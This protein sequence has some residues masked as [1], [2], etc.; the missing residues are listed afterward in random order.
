MGTL[1][2]PPL[3]AHAFPAAGSGGR[4]PNQAVA[5]QEC[6]LPSPLPHLQDPSTARNQFAAVFIADPPPHAYVPALNSTA[7]LLPCVAVTLPDGAAPASR[8]GQHQAWPRRGSAHSARACADKGAPPH[9]PHAHG[10]IHSGGLRV[11]DAGRLRELPAPFFA[12]AC[13]ARC[14][15][16]R[17]PFSCWGGCA[18]GGSLGGKSWVVQRVGQAFGWPYCSK[19]A[20][21]ACKEEAAFKVF[22]YPM[23]RA[24]SRRC[25]TIWSR[26][27]SFVTNHII[28]SMTHQAAEVE[29]GP[30]ASCLKL[31][32]LGLCCPPA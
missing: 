21:P 27:D 2:G 24:P 19:G 29:P 16:A 25:W 31:P 7:P 30:S 17:A 12:G 15:S 3:C 13:F 5:K 18:F 10:V 28:S 23:C 22:L 26:C 14:V 6:V 1:G 32:L 20:S 4:E 9:A 11:Q 8:G